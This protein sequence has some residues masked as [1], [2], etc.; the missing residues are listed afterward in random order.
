MARSPEVSRLFVC[1]ALTIAAA[2]AAPAMARTITPTE[3]IKAALN[4]SKFSVQSIALPAWNGGDV[5][6]FVE[7]G[8]GP[9]V[10]ALHP[11]T[12]R[13]DSFKLLIDDGHGPKA[14][15]P[16]TSRTFKG[17]VFQLVGGQ[18][19]LGHVRASLLDDGLYARIWMDDGRDYGIQP[20][21]TALPGAQFGLHVSYEKSDLVPGDW[22]CGNDMLGMSASPTGTTLGPAGKSQFKATGLKVVEIGVDS[23]FEFF[24]KN[25]SNA[26]TAAFDIENVLNAVEG[27]YETEVQ[28]TFE[29]TVSI[30]RTSA[31]DPYT[32]TNA[33]GS[34]S[35]LSEFQSYWQSQYSG[36][37]RDHAHLMS[38]KNWTSGG[39]IGVA[40]LSGVC[41]G[42][43][44]YGTVETKFT[45]NFTYRQ[46][47]SAHEMG[48]N[49]NAQHCDGQADCGIMCSGIGGCSGQLTKFGVQETTQITG[50]KNGHSGC[51][52]DL[53]DSVALPLNDPFPTTTLSTTNWVYNDGG[54]VNAVGVNEPSSPNALNLDSVGA[55]AADFDDD[56]DEV[57]TGFLLAAAAPN[58]TNIS[59]KVEHI[60][61][62]SGEQLLVYYWNNAL[63]WKLL[64]TITSD[65]IDQTSFTT[66]SHPIP[67]DAKHNELRLRFKTNGNETNDDW[68]IDD[69]AVSQPASG[70]PI[71]TSVS[72][73][74]AQILLDGTIT[75]TGS[76]FSGSTQV[77]IGSNV[78]TAGGFTIVNDTQITVSG[79][80]PSSLGT[81][82]VTVTNPSGTSGS[83][84][85]TYNAADPTLLIVPALT[86]NGGNFDLQ[87]AGQ[88]NWQAFLIVNLSFSTFQFNGSTWLSSL[89]LIPFGTLNSVGYQAISIPLSGVPGGLPIYT[90]YW[91]FPPGA[92]SATQGKVSN[93]GSTLNLF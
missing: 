13:S 64:N 86:N 25:A 15:E 24:Q 62:E 3:Q 45:T 39:V 74:T 91:T 90:Q 6:V 11:H 82:A 43:L 71:L 36:I 44:G 63:T 58:T 33:T 89:V 41:G 28:I 47:L 48:H 21:S 37:K 38:G 66:F 92:T 81:K 18:T 83:Q 57:R 22:K 80:I 49:W 40:Y 75:L 59:Y 5:Q 50:W 32:L 31:A 35:I 8:N 9:A 61:V 20:L 1:G 30:V 70:P 93:I 42:T 29:L 84:N 79:L 72:P 56:E 60:G 23:D 34:P 67:T 73:S 54:L 76:N 17:D 85:L 4:V 51:L 87:V 55:G 10:L 68:Y 69:V 77:T 78:L 53:P 16:P 12:I 26:T 65:G 88:P 7:L 19:L 27:I 52:P 2:L 14:V 46:S